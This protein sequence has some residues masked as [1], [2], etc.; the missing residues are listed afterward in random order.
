MYTFSSEGIILKRADFG[1]ADRLIT[2]FTKNK[3]KILS[4]AKGIRRI[5][6]RR[7]GNVE[8]LNKVKLFFAQSKSLPILTE[9]ESVQTYKNIKKDLKKVGY[10]YYLTEL[11]DQFFHDREENYKTFDLLSEALDNLDRINNTRTENIV[12]VF[13]L[14]I[15]S[16]AGYRPQIHT[17]IKCNKPLE[18]G[19]NLFSADLGGVLCES[20]G[21]QSPLARPISTEAV[22]VMRFMQEKPLSEVAKLNVSKNLGEELKN[23]LKFYLEFI[24]ERELVSADFAER[25]KKLEIVDRP[26]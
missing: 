20:C 24:L 21:R 10:A 19:G 12:R 9:A 1:E 26:Q 25:V 3:G 5:G 23:H 2:I 22:K 7:A 17:C 16:L 11:V 15:L 8:L 6:S 4:L 18:P 14:K 13:E